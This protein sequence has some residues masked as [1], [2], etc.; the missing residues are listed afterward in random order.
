MAHT[1][2]GVNRGP[3][4]RRRVEADRLVRQSVCQVPYLA[5][6]ARGSEERLAARRRARV[7]HIFPRLRVQQRHHQP[8]RLILDLRENINRGK[9]N[10]R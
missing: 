2:A 3:Y 4:R 9:I 6:H 7:Q 5:L 1:D 10:M 8:R